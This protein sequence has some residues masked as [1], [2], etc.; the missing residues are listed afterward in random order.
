M[1]TKNQNMVMDQTFERGDIFEE[2]TPR[3]GVAPQQFG[4]Q[5]Y[6]EALVTKDYEQAADALARVEA[7]QNFRSTLR[8]KPFASF[9]TL[10]EDIST[11]AQIS[12]PQEERERQQQAALDAA[13]QNS[14]RFSPRV[15]DLYVALLAE[16]E[17]TAYE[18][19]F[20]ITHRK[21]TEL[22]QS[23][24]L[25]VLYSGDVSWDLKLNRIETRLLGYLSGA[26]EL[27]KR[28][29]KEM[30]DDILQRRAQE[31]KKYP[32]RP[33]HRRKESRPGVDPMERLKEGERA[34]AFW[35]IYPAMNG[36]FREQSFSRWDAKENAWVEDEC[37]YELTETVSLSG[38]TDP[39]KGPIDFTMK[40][41]VISGTWISVPVPPTH[42]L[43][44]IE[45]GGRTYQVRQ[46]QHGDSVVFVEGEDR[47]PITIQ[48]ILAPS[49]D[50][51]FT[52]KNPDAVRT[53]NLPAEFS[54]ETSAHIADIAQ[55]KRGNVAR[56]FALARYAMRHIQY[57]A[58]KDKKESDYYN[59][60]YRTSPKGFP[61][62]VDE[63]RKGDCDTV[64]TYWSGL[65]AKLNIPTRHVIGHYVSGMDESGYAH[66]HGGTGH[67]WGDVWDE[68]NKE[69]LIKDATPFGDPNMEQTDQRGGSAIPGDY[70]EREAV[71]PSDEQLETLREKLAQHTEF[72]S[73]TEI[74]HSFAKSADIPLALARKIVQE[75]NEAENI[76]LPNNELVVDVLADVFDAVVESRKT[77]APAYEGPL[78]R[79]EGGEKI[80]H[81]VRHYIGAQAGDP[82]PRSREK[83]TETTREKHI[84]GG[85]DLFIIGD[86]SGSMEHTVED[87][88]LWQI[89]RRTE[90][91]VF[92]SLNRFTRKLDRAHLSAERALSVRTQGISF[93]G[94]GENDLDI[95]KPLSSLFTAHDK[96]KLWHSLTTQGIGN[97]DVEA[98]TYIRDQIKKE[99]ETSAQKGM[100]DNRL[101]IVIPCSDGGYVG[102]DSVKM[103]VLAQE[104][105]AMG[106]LVVG[107]GLT[108]TAASVPLVMHNPPHSYG[109]L[110]SDINELPLFVAKYIVSEAIKLFPEKAREDAQKLISLCLAKFGKAA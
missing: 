17:G 47:A 79:S 82:D 110:L 89:Q 100:Q 91:L 32:T 28:E 86:K 99:I 108:E 9:F 65:C 44:A 22:K 87:E 19:T 41:E 83:Q 96:V 60:L 45:T 63:V 51:K 104:L 42:G 76:R 49:P 85:F 98:L 64:N 36:Y 1:L 78:S 43:H 21:I 40:A 53:P 101:R 97:G 90:Y 24:D 16:F 88:K 12:L 67:G 31:L 54:D 14:A 3:E 13:A 30:D 75:V 71:R 33:P 103:R 37:V 57:L 38:N 61:G 15:A 5:A 20:T 95:D 105:G 35:S 84:V 48:I 2:R 39:D 29:G 62:A 107:V 73:Y 106:V 68:K 70:G 109:F 93:R 92:S 56:A 94:N 46:D 11:I 52:A 77:S 74:E 6:H 58:P 72:L 81:I 102:D 25:T 27:D 55:K 26:R 4:E 80:K 10:F 23:G 7:L 59:T 50:K 66:I 18:P 34:P 69:W 8:T